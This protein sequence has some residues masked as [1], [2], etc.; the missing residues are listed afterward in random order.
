MRYA[1]LTW[2]KPAID[3]TLKLTR[4]SLEQFV[5]NPEDRGSLQDAVGWL[6]EISGVLVMLEIDTAVLL[7]QEM[8]EVTR[9]LLAGKIANREAAYDSLMRGLIQLPNY[10][11]HLALGYPH[12]PLALL[13]LLN[14]LRALINRPALAS[15]SFFLPD[16]SI[17]I[18]NAKPAPALSDEKLQ[19]Y[20][21]KVRASYQKGLM[22]FLK[23]PNRMEG[24]KLMLTSFT[25]LQQATGNAPI[26]KLWWICEGILEALV[27]KGLPMSEAINT[28]LKQTDSFIKQLA[29]QGNAALH[30]TPNPKFVTNLLYYAANAKSNGP[31]ITAIRDTYHLNYCLPADALLQEAM[32][33][34]SGP[35]IELMRIVVNAIKD[36]FVRIEETLDIFMRADTPDVNDLQPLIEIMRNLAYTL[37]LLGLEAQAKSMMQQTAQIRAI[38]E[39]K[40]GY[41][42]PS[43]LKV[44]DA[45]LKV[46]AALDTLANRGTHAREQIQ[47]EQGLLETQF[48]EVLKVVVDEAKLE[49]TEMIQPI[50]NFLETSKA[51]DDLRLIPE[52]FHHIQGLLMMLAQPQAAKLVQLCSHYVSKHL[53]E[54]GHV[55]DETQ[56]RA[57]ADAIISLEFYLDTLAGNPLDGGRILNVTQ[58]CM[59]VLMPAA[60]PAH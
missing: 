6:H 25:H 29:E 12:M 44:T 49:L 8:E 35:D 47:Q 1:T 19:A 26:S 21:Q 24:L 55:P 42:L 17:N 50:L 46:E 52:R 32:R 45:I 23:G 60:T 37:H 53:I 9:N 41:E 15:N 31:R 22:A 57:L 13:P 16:V 48:S 7:V 2:V 56:R 54:E 5:E 3:D 39:G 59:N 43:M 58:H 51:D 28:L 10:L 27:Q 33:I 36:D 20:A 34:F 11:D 38:T 40:Q 30:T 14:R 18:P 4:Q